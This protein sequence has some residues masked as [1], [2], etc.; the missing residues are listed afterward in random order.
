MQRQRPELR[1]PLVLL[2]C[3]AMF[4]RDEPS[5]LTAVHGFL[6]LLH[7]TASDPDGAASGGAGGSSTAAGGAGWNCFQLEV[8]GFFRRSLTA[9]AH[10]PERARCTRAWCA[11]ARSSVSD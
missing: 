11:E 6:L 3:K 2:L 5:R 10:H 9:A 4:S 7:T 8:L 1:D